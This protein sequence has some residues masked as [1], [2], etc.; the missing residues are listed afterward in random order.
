M[1]P[2]FP[3]D[4]LLELIA[5]DQRAAPI[6]GPELSV[7][8]AQGGATFAQHAARHLAAAHGLAAENQTLSQVAATLRRGGASA[9][10]LTRE[11]TLLHR[12][13]LAALDSAPLPEP[14][15]QLAEIRDFPL[16]VTTA[17]DALLG[18]TIRIAR[19]RSAGP[20]VAT[21]GGRTDLPR[22]WL[23]GP[24][25]AL[26]HL[27]GRINAV[28]DFAF[29]EEDVLEFLHRMQSDAHRPEQLFDELRTRHLLLIGLGLPDWALRLF[30]RAIHGARLSQ[31]N[32][33][34]LVIAGDTIARDASLR[35]FLR[36]FARRVWIY[37]DGGSADFVRELHQRWQAAQ[38]E[39]WSTTSDGRAVP[40]EPAEMIDGAVYVSAAPADRTAA[41]QLAAK[42]DEAGL[43]VWFDRNDASRGTRYERG[44]RRHV[45]HCDLFVPLLSP[46]TDAQPDGAF[47]KEW[48]WALDRHASGAPGTRFV[49][50][51]WVGTASA[52]ASASPPLDPFPLLT[53]AGGQPPPEVLRA[54]IDAVRAARTQRSA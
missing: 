53:A 37:E 46:A 11:L 29:T 9:A 47:R 42:L 2:S 43:D 7:L 40:A 31:D 18:A 48:E 33:Q 38:E 34:T 27:F 1:A 14:L 44:L 24:R 51:V 52:P 49:Q 22:N 12:E 20:L 30:L 35:T 45:Q 36:D 10:L 3:W 54:C 19:E 17:P 50:P 26:F 5:T 39:G 13:V 21:L 28:P 23:Q 32:G 15:R 25:P 6:V 4:E 41:E 8:P 16:L